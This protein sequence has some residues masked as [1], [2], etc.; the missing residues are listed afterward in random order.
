ME[1]R[2]S[3]ELIDYQQA[4]R[5]MEERVAAIRADEADELVWLLQHPALYTAGTS[6]KEADLL[7]SGGLPVYRTGRG[8]Q[9][10][11]HGPGQRVAYVMLDLQRR[12]LDIRCYVAMLE[13]WL[14]ATLNRFSLRGE[15]R[16]GRVGIWIDRG[17]GRDDKIGAIGVRVRRWVTYHGISLNVEPDLSHYDGI[18]PCGIQ[19]HGV[20]S[21]VDLGLP[22]DMAEVDVQLA[23]AWADIFGGETI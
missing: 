18:V 16:E 22:I 13:D 12:K 23:Q 15:R 11:Y 9:Y 8:G 7:D 19:E 14:I 5:T 20:T 2:I 4:V 6:A 17:H 3:D 1:W 21:L 10:T